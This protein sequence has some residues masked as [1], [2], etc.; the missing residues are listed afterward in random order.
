M[1]LRSDDDE[2]NFEQ[3]WRNAPGS[4]LVALV[5]RTTEVLQSLARRMR[6]ADQPRQ[7]D[8]DD[9]AK[10]DDSPPPPMQAA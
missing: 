6:R 8:M 3:A 10:A 7:D 5:L 2:N 4:D 1:P 9:K